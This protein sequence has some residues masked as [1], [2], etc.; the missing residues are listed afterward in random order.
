M[1]A[2]EDF[3]EP[4]TKRAGERRPLP[5]CPGRQGEGSALEGGFPLPPCPA[6]TAGKPCLFMPPAGPAGDGRPADRYHGE[7]LPQGASED[8]G[9]PGSGT[10]AGSRAFGIPGGQGDAGRGYIPGLNPSSS[11]EASAPAA[12]RKRDHNIGGRPSPGW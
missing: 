9:R 11:S 8:A 3:E 2:F 12:G 5:L 10:G 1:A 7:A 6:T 4:A